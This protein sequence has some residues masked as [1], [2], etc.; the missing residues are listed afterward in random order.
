[1][2]ILKGL[3]GVIALTGLIISIVFI[4]RTWDI[5]RGLWFAA[6]ANRSQE[7]ANPL[8][9]IYVTIALAAGT[10]LVLGLAIGLPTRTKNA[11]RRQALQDASDLREATIRARVG[12]ADAE[13]HPAIEDGREEQN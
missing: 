5:V 6:N 1:M 10:G 12:V 4:V 3:L 2:K 13:N 9:Q 8:Q 7:F 11:V